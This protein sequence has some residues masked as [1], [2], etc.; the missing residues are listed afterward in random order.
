MV[1]CV[2]S[3][4]TFLHSCC[5]RLFTC[6]RFNPQLRICVASGAIGA[7]RR[8]VGNRQQHQVLLL[9]SQTCYVGCDHVCHRAST[10]HSQSHRHPWTNKHVLN[11]IDARS[12]QEG[13]TYRCKVVWESYRCK[14]AWERNHW[15]VSTERSF[16]TGTEK[17]QGC[18][19]HVWV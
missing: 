7:R 3:F 10:H 11:L 17:I 14:V 18:M 1:H 13:Q 8:P 4:R 16:S 6:T 12:R 19:G 2:H 9:H 5:T 15:E